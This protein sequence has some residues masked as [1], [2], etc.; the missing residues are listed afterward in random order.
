MSESLRTF[1]ALISSLEVEIEW[2]RVHLSVTCLSCPSLFYHYNLVLIEVIATVP[3]LCLSYILFIQLYV[4]LGRQSFKNE[5][6]MK[7]A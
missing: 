5:M 4:Q 3:P 1:H 7:S 6:F 2:D